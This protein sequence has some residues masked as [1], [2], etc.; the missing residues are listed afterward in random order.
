MAEI[1]GS[2][3]LLNVRAEEAWERA[4]VE[5]RKR[6]MHARESACLVGRAPILQLRKKY[7]WSA[8]SCDNE[9]ADK[10]FFGGCFVVG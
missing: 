5:T 2:R 10:A 3:G 8:N 6:R 9:C 1:F 4:R 7:D